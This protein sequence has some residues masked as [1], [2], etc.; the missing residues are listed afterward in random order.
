MNNQQQGVAIRL[1]G[2]KKTFTD[3]NI[4]LHEL[5][6]NIHAGETLVLLGPSGCGKTTTLRMIAGL[7]F[8]DAGG[9]VLFNEQDVTALPIEKRNVGMVF[10]SYALFPN[11]NV[12]DNV[13]YG[14]KVQKMAPQLIAEKVATMLAMMDI[15]DLAERGIDQLSGGQRQRVALAR[16]I[17]TE[18]Q[19][20]LLDEPLAALD[21]ILRNRLRSDINQLLRKLGITAIYVTHDQ[22]EAMALGD[23]IVVMD[24]GLVAQIGR[25]RDIYFKPENDFVADFIG[26]INTFEGEVCDEQ[27]QLPG[28]EISCPGLANGWQKFYCRPED[29]TVTNFESALSNSCLTG[30]VEQVLFI[31]DRNRLWL[32]GVNHQQV[33]VD[34]IG[35][36]EFDIG[37]K[38]TLQIAPKDIINTL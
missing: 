27:M 20:L 18:P 6:L 14:L 22:E 8:P 29:I 35:R 38:V 25:P 21:A 12:A 36:K 34:C 19:V 2:I 15:T 17:I 3:G 9:Q 4:A 11:M 10:Q 31:G 26:Q 5:D 33:I 16:A 1:A 23:R 30:E 7:E 28:G 32:K 24:Q 13:G 37:Q